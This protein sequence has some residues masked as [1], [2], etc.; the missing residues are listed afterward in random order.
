MV[1][2]PYLPHPIE[3]EGNVADAAY[4]I[5]LKF[6]KRVTYGHAFS[7]FIIAALCIAPLHYVPLWS[8]VIAVFAT[9]GGLTAVRGVVKGEAVEQRISFALFPVL[10]L[11]FAA[12]I[13]SLAELGWPVWTVGIAVLGNALYTLVCGRDHSYIGMFGLSFLGVFGAVA[14]EGIWHQVPVSTMVFGVLIGGSALFYFVYD[15]ASLTSRRRE[16][17]VWG[18]VVDLYRDLLN[19]LGYGV[20]VWLHWRRYPIW[21]WR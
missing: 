16:R 1:V 4:D 15:L 14:L 18:A 11:A 21:T 7:I 5:R 6:I 9:L 10:L 13:R 17:E 20:R 12:L 8:S 2:P 3:I 19:I